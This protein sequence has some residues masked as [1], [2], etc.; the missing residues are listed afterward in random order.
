M[1]KR[2]KALKA[3][4]PLLTFDADARKSFITG[5]HKRKLERRQYAQTKLAKQARKEK[6]EARKEKREWMKQQ[7][8]VG[9]GDAL[10]AD[11]PDEDDG[12]AE[13][14]VFQYEG[15]VASTTVTP[16]TF[17]DASEP[18]EP[19]SAAGPRA[20]APAPKP[21][22]AKPGAGTK[23]KVAPGRGGR[24]SKGKATR[25]RKNAKKARR[26]GA[27]KGPTGVRKNGKMR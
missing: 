14:H 19:R 9:L 8:S 4:G 12:A 3:R 10:D 1:G 11:D 25:T 16:L 5:F 13:K 6:L 23:R 18:A 17:S 24:L 27:A 21:K 26:Q 7:R 22:L 15:M 2:G 20:P